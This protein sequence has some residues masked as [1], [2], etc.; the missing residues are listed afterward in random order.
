MV[1][2]LTCIG[3]IRNFSRFGCL[4]SM[5]V[6]LAGCGDRAGASASD[7]A[8]QGGSPPP[9]SPTMPDPLAGLPD[10]ADTLTFSNSRDCEW[11]EVAD[12]LFQNATVFGDDYVARPGTVRVPNVEQPVV[13]RLS[14]PD[15]D[16]PDYVVVSLDFEGQWLG[17]K[18]SGLTDA[19]LEEGDGVFG[20]GVRFDAPVEKVMEAL[21]REGFDINS[22][23]TMRERTISQ[24]EYGERSVMVTQVG[25]EGDEAIFYCNQP[26]LYEGQSFSY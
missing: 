7:L 26:Y 14:R 10:L 17:L 20:R 24:D 18:V 6:F 11:G 22:D 5:S 19:F 23:G 3:A 12:G 15:R 16:I 9:K 1:Q 21:A 2:Y 25:R 4:V 8:E 13:A